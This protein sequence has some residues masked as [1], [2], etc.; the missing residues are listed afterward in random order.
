MSQ[1]AKCFNTLILYTTD[2]HIY[3]WSIKIRSVSFFSSSDTQKF[4]HFLGCHTTSINSSLIFFLSVSR[5]S[6]MPDHP[7]GIWICLTKSCP[8]WIEN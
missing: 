8:N 4:H 2:T 5:F 6:N 7:Y 3:H 1:W